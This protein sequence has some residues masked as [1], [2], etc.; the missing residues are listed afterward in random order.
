MKADFKKVFT[1]ALVD[2]ILIFVL[3]TINFF[4]LSH[5]LQ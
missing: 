4:V 3:S 2:C 5:L 1:F